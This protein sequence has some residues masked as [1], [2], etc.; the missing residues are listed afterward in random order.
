MTEAQIRAKVVETA[1]AW[2][3]CNEADKSHRKI[4]DVY[5]AHKPRARAYKVKYTDAWCATFVSAVAIACGL[6]DIMPTECSC[7]KMIALY[8]KLGRWQEAD[9]YIPAAG[10]LVMYD[11][12]DNGKG[13]NKGSPDHVGIVESCTAGWIEVIEGN[14]GDAVAY[15]DL[16]VGGKYIRGYCLPDYASKA[17]EV[18]LIEKY[19]REIS[20]TL[21]ELYKGCT[22]EEVRALQILLIGRGYDVGDTGADG[23]FGDD[24]RRAVEAL[25]RDHGL[26]EDGIAG[27]DTMTVLCTGNTR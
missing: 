11:W 19:G 7:S 12:D 8:K 13:D 10:D 5:N 18:R 23:V 3:G 24:T 25:Q 1:A 15:R 20:I 2:L 14:L 22:G 4:V 21:H 16:Q 26:D 27:K 6:T 17:D 9:D